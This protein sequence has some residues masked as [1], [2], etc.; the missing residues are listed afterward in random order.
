[1]P[2]T[3]NQGARQATE[4]S[5]R[6][7]FRFERRGDDF[8]YYH[9]DPVAIDGPRWWIVMAAVAA[10][11]FVLIL[12]PGILP[13][14]PAM[15]IPAM[16]FVA[17]PLA[18]LVYAAGSGWKA[19]FR[20]MRRIDWL[21]IVLFFVLNWIVTIAVGLL[22]VKFFSHEVNP[23]GAT[24]AAATGLE[25]ILFFLRTGVQL[26][27]EELFTILPFLAILCWLT[28][29][30]M[31]RKPAVALA[32]LAAAVIFALAHLPTYHWHLPQALI[33][34]VPVRIVLLLPYLLTKNIWVSTGVHVLNDWAIF[35]L[36]MLV[37][38]AVASG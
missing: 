10:G 5:P 32:A 27:G 12:A 11:F 36:P 8:P 34:L 19:L 13:Q 21:W 24:V 37:G 18:A 23:A 3:D 9:E 6:D 22:I 14:G 7:F 25:K 38:G 30:G 33:G 1:M 4:A 17:I 26:F 29:R 31:G 2:I 20:R 28:Q 15:L 16:L 35:G